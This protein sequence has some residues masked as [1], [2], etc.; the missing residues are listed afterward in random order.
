MNFLLVNDDGEFSR[1]FLTFRETLRREGN[2]V[3]SFI[4]E[5][6][7][8][9]AS[10]SI[11]TGKPVRVFS[12]RPYEHI[13][14]G[15]PTDC[16][17]IGVEYMSNQMGAPPDVVVSGVNR[18]MNYGSCSAYSGTVA[19][20]VVAS[21]AGYPAVAISADERVEE[22]PDEPLLSLISNYRVSTL[23]QSGALN[24]NISRQRIRTVV[25]ENTLDML[26]PKAT[27]CAPGVGFYDVSPISSS[28]EPNFDLLVGLIGWRNWLALSEADEMKLVALAET[29]RLQLMKAEN[30]D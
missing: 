11:T 20:A 4:P 22:L 13:V 25:L 29:V 19:A 18:G 8:S 5:R 27:E 15:T 10:K 23:A 21:L 24:L 6:D 7:C 14:C 28:A 16:S 1:F 9:G 2:L 3:V 17:I 12:P 26:R 30:G